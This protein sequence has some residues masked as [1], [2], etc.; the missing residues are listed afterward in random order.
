MTII[1]QTDKETITLDNHSMM[2]DYGMI[3]IGEIRKD[4]C[5]DGQVSK[6]EAKK[7]IMKHLEEFLK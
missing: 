6:E 1:I 7:I 5:L 4:I 2:A 3:A